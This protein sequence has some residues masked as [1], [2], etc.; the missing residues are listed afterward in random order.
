LFKKPSAPK[1]LAPAPLPTPLS[2]ANGAVIGA[3]QSLQN[4]PALNGT[5][6]GSA[7]QNLLGYQ[8]Q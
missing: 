7:R 1:T 3:G 8:A 2:S 4:N 6:L 5:V